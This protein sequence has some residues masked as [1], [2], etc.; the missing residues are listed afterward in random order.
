MNCRLQEEWRELQQL[1]EKIKQR[2][3]KSIPRWHNLPMQCRQGWNML[4]ITWKKN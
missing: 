4:S 2:P 3:S 1:F